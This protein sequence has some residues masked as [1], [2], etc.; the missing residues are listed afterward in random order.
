LSHVLAR[1]QSVQQLLSPLL[2]REQI[3][4]SPTAPI[5]HTYKVRVDRTMP[6]ELIGNLLAPFCELWGAEVVFD[7]SDYDAS[8]YQLG[9]LHQSDGYMIWLDWRIHHQSMA[10][11][12]AVDWLIG[13]I[14]TLREATAAP[15]WVNNWPERLA[16]GDTLFGLR[17]NERSQIRRFNEYLFASIE[18]IAGCE[19]IDLAGIAYEEKE[20]VYDLRNDEISSY[21]FSDSINIRLARHLGTQLIP[22]SFLPRIKA[23]AVDLDDTLYRGILAE[24]GWLRLDVSEG[25]YELQRLLVRLKNSGILLAICSR[26]E[27][28]DVKLLFEN[29]AD[30]PLRWSDFAIICANWSSK[31]DN[32]Q[33]IA[34]QLNIDT[35]AMLFIDDNPAQLLHVGEAIPE[36]NLLQAEVNGMDTVIRLSYYPGL[37]QIRPDQEASLRAIDIQANQIRKNIKESSSEANTYLESLQM[38]VTIYLN[39]VSHAA[40]LYDLSN[41]TNQFNLALRRMTEAESHMVMDKEQYVTLTIRLKDIVS[42]S[43]IIGAFVCRLDGQHAHVMESIFSCRALGRDIESVSFACLLEQLTLRGIEHISF[44]VKDGPRNAPAFEWLKRYI[45]GVPNDIPMKGLRNDVNAVSKQHP[46]KV[47]VID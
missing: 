17:V 30:F 43:G 13:R 19:L 4:R 24:D 2:T 6:F 36:I 20:V 10:V 38:I 28:Q 31:A 37:Y 25:H 22:A 27:E 14:R 8:L 12:E 40:R 7:Y 34:Q 18:P 45:Q 47:E 44:D 26:N 35:S 39:E 23:I 32:L 16:L 5:R 42:D 46:S 41:K 1:L 33:Q 15:I 21:P 11:E 3:T 9:G 29:R